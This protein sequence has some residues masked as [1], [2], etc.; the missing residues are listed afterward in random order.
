MRI[1]Y[2][3]GF[4]EF[5]SP[6][7]FLL[8]LLIPFFLWMDRRVRKGSAI[9]F[10]SLDALKGTPAGRRVIWRRVLPYLRSV[11]L[12][13]LI[14]AMAR[15]RAGRGVEES[16]TQGIDI[17]LVLDCSTSMLAED[18]K[19]MNRIEAA[20]EV[21]IEFVKGRQNDRIGLVVFAAKA[22]TQCPLTIDYGMLV[23]LIKR[24][25]TGII[26]DGTAIGVALAT[27]VSRLRN[28]TAKSKV[29]I[30]LT[31]GRN[32]T[33]EIDP[34]TADSMAQDYGIRVYTIGMGV[35]GYALYPVNDPFFGKRYVQMPVE[36]DED[37]L[38]KIASDTGGKYFR[39]T[40]TEKLREIYKEIDRMEKTKIEVKK[41]TEYR[42]LATFPIL[43][44]LLLFLGELILSNTYLR[45]LP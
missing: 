19:P 38:T 30:L 22:F 24:V 36:I 40:D 44:G 18:F 6:Q 45:K 11:V 14:I 7:Y 35:K 34:I 20:K 21:A 23:N 27:A 2:P 31:D 17:M 41:Y 8:L 9:R 16:F 39:A 1:P 25:E 10:S 15:P 33:G 3:G 32:N 28:S 4:L 13:F 43:I 29:I 5:A 37:L 26:Q 42:E 12:L